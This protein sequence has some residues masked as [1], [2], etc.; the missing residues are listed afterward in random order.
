MAKSNF[1][2]TSSSQAMGRLIQGLQIGGRYTL[3]N[4]LRNPSRVYSSWLAREERTGRDVLLKFLPG[5]LYNDE[6]VVDDLKREAGRS[7]SLNHKGIVRVFDYVDDGQ[8]FALTTESVSGLSLSSLRLKKVNRVLEV[9]ELNEWVPQICKALSY[10]YDEV[11]ALHRDL[12]P[13][14]LLLTD[15]GQIKIA[16]FGI[17][18]VIDEAAQ[19][20]GLEGCGLTRGLIYKSP[21]QVN[22]EEA[23][24]LDDVYSLGVTL[25]E[26][27]ASKPPFFSGDLATQIR[28]K[29][30]VPPSEKRSLLR[31]EAEYIPEYWEEIIAACLAKDPSQRP[32]SMRDLQEGLFAK[33]VF[34][35]ST[36]PAISEHPEVSL[37]A[38]VAVKALADEGRVEGAV[39]SAIPLIHH[40]EPTPEGKHTPEA[41]TTPVL[42][43]T[44]QVEKV[45]PVV[46]LAEEI[47]PVVSEAAAVVEEVALATAPQTAEVA[48]IVELAEEITPLTSEPMAEVEAIRPQASRR[49]TEVVPTVE[50]SLS[51]PQTPQATKPVSVVEPARPAPVKNQTVAVTA[52]ATAGLA[53]ASRL[54]VKKVQPEVTQ[55]TTEA[56]KETAPVIATVATTAAVGLAAAG[57]LMK[58]AQPEIEQPTQ[59]AASAASYLL[60][61]V[62]FPAAEPQPAQESSQLMGGQESLMGDQV[63]S[64]E[65][66]AFEPA[67]QE[68]PQTITE[69]V[70]EKIAEPAEPLSHR[71]ATEK[72]IQPEVREEL[73]EPPRESSLT[74]RHR[75][76]MEREVQP[77]DPRVVRPPA[78]D[79]E[80]TSEAP[81][82]FYTLFRGLGVASILFL[83]LALAAWMFLP[84]EWTSQFLSK[85]RGTPAETLETGAAKPEVA[86]PQRK[87]IV[88]PDQFDTIQ[89]AIDAAEAGDVVKIKPGVYV[90]GL[91]LKDG[92]HLQ[93]V[94]RDTC[95]IQ[96][97]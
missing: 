30:P 37:D 34:V 35:A 69:Q 78:R 23:T 39:Q 21:Q 6:L 58:K 68:S 60:E 7:F 12:D 97:A 22:G 93:G 82:F 25:Y 94:D 4:C 66:L 29:T 90:E 24:V 88:V 63:E 57:R 1:D 92:V 45:T 87:T 16:D 43:E 14:K 61:E 62:P 81:S 2:D 15:S 79:T 8:D 44:P 17:G 11:R 51:Q 70:A 77:R 3:K 95:V 27:L 19:R 89:A 74:E 56:P 96:L 55:T 49:V 86:I 20:M 91:V 38:A 75:Q 32:Q 80:P 5:E 76:P 59:E 84:T 41:Q 28:E 13:G 36:V 50:E 71:V 26:L 73:Q 85:V 40:S 18:A 53:P 10:A 9:D 48:P 67:I 42:T 83:A 52:A 47:L 64:E 33:K 54:I 46:E 65:A 31:I 72:E